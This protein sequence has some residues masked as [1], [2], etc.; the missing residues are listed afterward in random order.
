[1]DGLSSNWKKLQAKLKEESSA[2]T[3][4][5]RKANGVQQR[6]AKRQNKSQPVVQDQASVKR[7]VATTPRQMGGVQSTKVEND[8]KSSRSTSLAI[9]AADNDISSE[10][11]AEAY[12]L[13]IKDNSILLSSPKDQ[14][15][16]GLTEGLSLG[17][18][19]TLDCEMVGVGPGGHKSALARVS[20]VDFHGKQIYDSYVKPR[21]LVTDW[22]TN[23]SG[24]SRK[25]MR[26]A[27]DFTE[28][29]SQVRQILGNRVL[30]GHDV[31]HDLDALE[32]SHPPRDIRDTSKHIPFKKYGHGPKPA[33][34]VLARRLLGVEIQ[35]GAHS[36]IEDARAT[37]LLFRK[38]KSSFDVDHASRYTPK[39]GQ[40]SSSQKKSKKKR[41]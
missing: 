36:S 7:K 20:I 38:H 10:A 6:E 25:D 14:I 27:R 5:K 30:I 24:I 1:M 34:R 26:F 2:Q 12:D 33:L 37:L 13:G 8:T 29:Q 17:K 28:V 35:T 9:W 23:Y 39:P 32:L 31:K 18:Y 21:E 16:H 11:L 19:I 22:R 41:K 4:I 40:G 3:P 15:N